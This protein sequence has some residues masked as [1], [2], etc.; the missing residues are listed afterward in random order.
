MLLAIPFS[1]LVGEA[2]NSINNLVKS[3]LRSVIRMPIFVAIMSFAALG[4]IFFGVIAT[5]FAQ[6]YHINTIEWP[7][8]GFWA[9]AQDPTTGKIFSPELQGYL[10]FKDNIQSGTKAFSFSNHALI[11]GLD[12]YICQWCKDVREYRT[13]GFNQTAEENHDWLKKGE[14]KYFII[15][16]QTANRFGVNQTN[17]KV[18]DV[19]VR[20]SGKFKP[21][22]RNNAVVIF[23]VV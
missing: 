11:I 20:N 1:L 13:K 10:W 5:S 21:V 22:F 19:A 4:I 12:K 9:Y 3:V 2:I 15:D 7:P 8:G 16:T 6:K 23:E 17:E 18:Q 14:Y